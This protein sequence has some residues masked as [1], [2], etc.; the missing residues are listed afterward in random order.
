MKKYILF[1][2]IMSLTA[3]CG[4]KI[5]KDPDPRNIVIH[6]FEAMARNDRVALA[7]YLDLPSL[8]KPT[9]TDYALQM[10]SARSFVNPEAVL[11]DLTK[12]GLTHTRWSA[13]QK[14]VGEAA[15]SGD[16]A[17]IEVS[18]LDN[19]TGTQY[20]NHFGLRRVGDIWRIFSF[21]VR[22]IGKQ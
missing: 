2:I 1:F 5:D 16:T 12:G 17:Y 7:H 22:N 11:D 8:L 9:G 14:V 21:S 6:M 3:G 13:M 4:P 18:F 19:S 10:D 20:Y 15:Q